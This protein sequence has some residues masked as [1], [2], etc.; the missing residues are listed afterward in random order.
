MAHTLVT[1]SRTKHAIRSRKQLR[2][3][4]ASRRTTIDS[5]LE[6]NI[7]QLLGFDPTANGSRWE[8]EDY[9]CLEHERDS[10]L[11]EQSSGR[12]F[13]LFGSAK[14][15]LAWLTNHAAV[16]IPLSSWKRLIKEVGSSRNGWECCKRPDEIAGLPD[17]SS[18]LGIVLPQARTTA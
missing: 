10:W 2:C 8:A 16:N 4:A 15:K 1:P 3:F 9:F 12:L 6:G 14:D 17:G 11:R 5:K 18:L 7:R 13:P